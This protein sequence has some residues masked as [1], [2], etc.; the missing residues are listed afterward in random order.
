MLWASY[1]PAVLPAGMQPRACERERLYCE[2]AAYEPSAGRRWCGIARNEVSPELGGGV[3]RA[4]ESWGCWHSQH[5]EPSPTRA[6]AW[7][8]SAVGSPGCL[9]AN[10]NQRECPAC[11]TTYVE[12]A[13]FCRICGRPR[14]RL[15]LPGG[16]ADCRALRQ[17]SPQSLMCSQSA[18]SLLLLWVPY[19]LGA[20]HRG[21]KV[22]LQVWPCSLV[23]V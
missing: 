10:N 4:L 12:D 22:L 3:A 20:V 15:E 18:T 16:E 5:G 6:W 1:P 7:D 9:D 8:A 23:M 13:R 21:F 19:L 14:G 11:S 17:V 2:G